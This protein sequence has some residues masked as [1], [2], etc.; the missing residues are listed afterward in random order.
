MYSSFFCTFQ[1]WHDPVLT[2]VA[3]LFDMFCG[4][5]HKSYLL[6]FT[7][8][9]LVYDVHTRL[10]ADYHWQQH[11]PYWICCCHIYFLR[12]WKWKYVQ[13]LINL[14]ITFVN[15]YLLQPPR[16]F[17]ASFTDCKP[18]IVDWQ[19]I[20]IGTPF[21]QCTITTTSF[22]RPVFPAVTRVIRFPLKGVWSS[23]IGFTCRMLFRSMYVHQL[24]IGS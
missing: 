18:G 22:L 2:F 10:S 15:F 5:Q 19:T 4:N 20:R 16:L 24:S 9:G 7:A 17:C 8:L 14:Y 23:P 1:D 3:K 13:L 21:W 12:T 6:H 11:T